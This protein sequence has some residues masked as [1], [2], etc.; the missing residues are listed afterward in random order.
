MAE[1]YS[2]WAARWRVPLGFIFGAAYLV[3][4]QPT[5]KFLVT[6]ALIALAGLAVRAYAAGYLDKGRRLASEGPYAR[7]R[8]PLYFGSSLIGTGLA[9]ASARWALAAAFVAYFLA[10]Y[11]PVMRREEQDLRRLYG[12]AVEN[13]V[14]AVPLFFPSLRRASARTERFQWSRYS[15]NREYEA[16]F[17]YLAALIFLALKAYLR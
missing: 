6:G 13:Y 1:N 14:R 4:A 16:A 5:V 9:V 8:N 17:G 3:F 10:V 15:A 11:G 12:D 7:T 2:S